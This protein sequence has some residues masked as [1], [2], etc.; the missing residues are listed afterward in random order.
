MVDPTTVE[1]AEFTVAGLHYEGTNEEGGI[2]ALWSDLEDEASTLDSVRQG[3]EWYGVS[4][5]GDPDTGEFEYVAG[6]RA[7]SEAG[8]PDSFTAVDVPAATYVRFETTLP[9]I[10]AAMHEVH[11]EWLPASEYD[12]AMGPEF[13]RYPA[14]FDRTDP[15][16]TFEVFVPVVPA[17]A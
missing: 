10:E 7:D 13:E 4:Y 11:T 17:D 6:V 12:L 14:D 8:V 5:G 1:E 2:A 3:P 9:R 16:G 15:D